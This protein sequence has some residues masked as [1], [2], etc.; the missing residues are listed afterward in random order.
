MNIYSRGRTLPQLNRSELS[1]STPNNLNLFDD[2]SV[3][4][5]LD[6]KL[7]DL[8]YK[9]NNVVLEKVESPPTVP[10]VADND[11]SNNKTENQINTN[12]KTAS[13][14]TTTTT[15]KSTRT[16]RQLTSNQKGF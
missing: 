6:K 11:N 14:P 9:R 4:T 10:V 5:R 1:S 16:G 3:V 8:E 12:T 2:E 13:T 7:K 15:A